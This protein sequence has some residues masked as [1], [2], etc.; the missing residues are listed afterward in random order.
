M[1]ARESHVNKKIFGELYHQVNFGY[2]LRTHFCIALN[3]KM[4]SV[5]YG[6]WTYISL[7]WY[8]WNPPT[9]G[10][11]GT[12]KLSVGKGLKGT[13]PRRMDSC[14]LVYTLGVQELLS[15]FIKC[16]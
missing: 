13:L 14:R 5:G 4:F 15:F 10:F 6:H 1:E 3:V 12:S 8:R 11:Y 9:S 16:T 2:N 7:I